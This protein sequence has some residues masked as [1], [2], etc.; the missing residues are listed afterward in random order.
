MLLREA[1]K[2]SHSEKLSYIVI[3]RSEAT[4]QSSVASEA[5]QSLPFNEIATLPA[6]A[7]NDNITSLLE[8]K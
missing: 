4:K 2:N 5:R 6:V 8:M 7:R 1:K 3:A